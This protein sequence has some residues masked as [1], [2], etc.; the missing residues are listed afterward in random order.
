MK[1]LYDSSLGQLEL[2]L[3]L[4]I[5]EVS[6]WLFDEEGRV[7]REGGD[8]WDYADLPDLLRTEVGLPEPEAQSIA[9]SFLE[10]ARAEG[11]EQPDGASA[12]GN[13][14]GLMI[15]TAILV[16]LGVGIWTIASWVY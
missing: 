4:R 5:G 9:I 3:D 12:I 13:T 10:A 16:A 11:H 6:I 1:R 7:D 8:E 15:V 2:E 14:L